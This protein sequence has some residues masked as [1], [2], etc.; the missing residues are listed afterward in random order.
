MHYKIQNWVSQ[1]NINDFIDTP[2]GPNAKFLKTVPG[3]CGKH[4]GK[5]FF[6]SLV[7]D[8]KTRSQ[9][10]PECKKSERNL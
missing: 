4:G 5:F 3:K 6:P 1:P 2:H 10:R 7:F 9:F 8:S